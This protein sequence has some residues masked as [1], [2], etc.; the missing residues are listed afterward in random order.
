MPIPEGPITVGIDG[1]Y[2]R[3]REKSQSHFEVTVE[4]SVT[5]GRLGRYLGLVLR[6][7]TKPRRRL[8]EVLKDQGW[9]GNQPV[10]F[11]T[12]G[13]DTVINMARDMAPHW[14]IFSTGPTS[15]CATPSCSN[16]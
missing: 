8:H 5:T 6:H 9:Q 10:A 4:K 12:D 16:M 7:D 1:G 2:V 13:G 14:S 3:S 11:M 15:P